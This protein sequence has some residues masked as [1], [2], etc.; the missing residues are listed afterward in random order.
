MQGGYRGKNVLYPPIQNMGLL[1]RPTLD[2][3]EET[4]I[5]LPLPLNLEHRCFAKYV[6]TDCKIGFGNESLRNMHASVILKI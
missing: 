2:Y 4:L 6:D 3:L 1:S 5:A